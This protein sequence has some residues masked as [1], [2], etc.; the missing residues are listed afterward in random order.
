MRE[1]Y[2]KGMD[3]TR[4]FVSGPLDPK[5]NPY[6]FYCQIC[7]GNI[8][9]YGRGPREIL[10]H[11][12]TELHLRKDQR[13]RYEYLAIEDPVT[14][15][16]RHQVR[17][18]DGKVLTPR[19]LVDELPNF[20]DVPL[21]DIGEKFPFYDEFMAGND[22]MASSSG[23]RM[24]VQVSI[25]SSFLPSCGNL[26]L[27]RKLWKDIGVVV[28]HQALFSDFNWEKERTLVS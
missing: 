12:A 21:V 3:W 4:T 15:V 20:K 19:Q 28:N 22:Y 11:H 17:G 7:K 2:F 10:R 27:L 26:S 24:R 5:W 1:E 8:S 6:K 14:E 23:N 9:I 16:I 25:L 18:K 13:W